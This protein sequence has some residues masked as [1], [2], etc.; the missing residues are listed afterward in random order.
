M[1]EDNFTIRES[2]PPSLTFCLSQSEEVL[3]FSAEE[4]RVYGKKIEDG[5]EKA[6]EVYE[7]ILRF[8]RGEVPP[9]A[10]KKFYVV[11]APSKTEGIITDSKRD[12]KFASTGN[13]GGSS[14]STLGDSFREIHEDTRKH[15]VTE[16]FLLPPT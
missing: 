15:P 4:T 2:T 11:W 1:S 10:G 8:L 16:V 14:Y 13:S 5:P 3:F 6:K 9:P 7:G 12:A